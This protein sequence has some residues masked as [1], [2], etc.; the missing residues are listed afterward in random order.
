MRLDYKQKKKKKPTPK[1]NV[2]ELIQSHFCSAEKWKK[3]QFWG[4]SDK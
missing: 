3:A 2:K 4:F 1:S